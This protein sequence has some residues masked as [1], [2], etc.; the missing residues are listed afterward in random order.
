MSITKQLITR[1]ISQRLLS[2]ICACTAGGFFPRLPF[3]QIFRHKRWFPW[4]LRHAAE[5]QVYF[6]IRWWENSAFS[7]SMY[8]CT[9]LPFVYIFTTFVKFSFLG[10]APLANCH[11]GFAKMISLPGWNQ[12]LAGPSNY[13]K[14][15][16]WQFFRCKSDCFSQVFHKGK[17]VCTI[18][19]CY[20]TNIYGNTLYK[21][22]WS[23]IIFMSS[24]QL[25]LKFCRS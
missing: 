7:N 25:I 14:K 24:W 18:Q 13:P 9:V 1:T 3:L 16:H 10:W 19:F 2:I 11:S 20:T 8:I 4:S 22:F 15:I 23:A 5:F 12:F 21:S 17:R 6:N